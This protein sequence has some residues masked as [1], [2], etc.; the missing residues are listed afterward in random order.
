MPHRLAYILDLLVYFLI[1][2]IWFKYILKDSATEPLM[3]PKEHSSGF[4]RFPSAGA[5][6][7]AS[8]DAFLILG[9]NMEEGRDIL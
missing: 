5:Q 7:V 6:S 2:V 1:H 3:I 8:V 9:S 4:I